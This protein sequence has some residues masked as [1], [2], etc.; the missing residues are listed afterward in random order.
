LIKFE[1]RNALWHKDKRNSEN[2]AIHL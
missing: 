1:H 2:G